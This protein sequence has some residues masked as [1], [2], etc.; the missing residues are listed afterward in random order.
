[1]R[2]SL[3][4]TVVY[5]S[6]MWALLAIFAGPIA[7]LFR[8]EGTSRELIVFFCHFAAGSFLFNGA[9]FVASAAFNNLGY[10]TYST[11]FNWGRSTL[12]T[13]PFVWA[14]AYFFGAMGVI[15]GWGL[16]AVV[17]GVVSM[18]VCFRVIRRIEA[19]TRRPTRPC[20][21]RH[22]PGNRRFRRPRL[23]HCRSSWAIGGGSG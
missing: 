23:R 7:T 15:A 5:V 6:V 20:W 11:L 2:D 10:P 9:I 4:F 21:V 14:G 12:G 17:F 1:M 13:I 19:G 22:L 18:L 8:A 3:M 16:G